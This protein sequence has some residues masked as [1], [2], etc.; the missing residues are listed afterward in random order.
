MARIDI[1]PALLELHGQPRC[2]RTE[3]AGGRQR[4]VEGVRA[5]VAG[6]FVSLGVQ[7]RLV[8]SRSKREGAAEHTRGPVRARDLLIVRSGTNHGVS[9]DATPPGRGAAATAAS[10]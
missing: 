10:P 9:S 8:V 7:V 1:D 2:E 5:D 6:A 3:D 4:V